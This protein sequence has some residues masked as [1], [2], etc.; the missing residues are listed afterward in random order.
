MLSSSKR[1]GL[2]VAETEGARGRRRGAPT[3][4][5]PPGGPG[6]RAPTRQEA[7][8]QRG[9]NRARAAAACTA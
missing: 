4:A 3:A 9:A 5:E 8:G 2:H 1:P 7:G 6:G